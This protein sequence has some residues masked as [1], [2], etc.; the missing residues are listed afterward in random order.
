MRT[1]TDHNRRTL[2]NALWLGV[3]AWPAFTGSADVAAFEGGLDGC[4]GEGAA[5]VAEGHVEACEDVLA[6]QQVETD[7]QPGGKPDAGVPFDRPDAEWQAVDV[8]RD[9]TPITDDRIGQLAGF[10]VKAQRSSFSIGE[11]RHERPGVDIHPNRF[12][13]LRAAHMQRDNGTRVSTVEAVRDGYSAHVK[14]S[15]RGT[16]RTEGMTPGCL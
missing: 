14:S 11:N 6:A 10:Q 7:A 16:R 1:T 3:G 2:V 5:R 15:G 13:P 8:D 9:Q 4:K 12:P